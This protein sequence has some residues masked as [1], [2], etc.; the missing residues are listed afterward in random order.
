M[1]DNPTVEA[2][3]VTIHILRFEEHGSYSI[4]RMPDI[5]RVLYRVA[6]RMDDRIGIE[7][8]EIVSC[9]ESRHPQ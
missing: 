7:F 5:H 1:I 2:L 3:W 6:R 4:D 9:S 8:M